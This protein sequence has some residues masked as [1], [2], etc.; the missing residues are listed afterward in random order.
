MICE[1]LMTARRWCQAPAL[2]PAAA[3][4]VLCCLSWVAAASDG[5]PVSP[6]TA[7]ELSAGDESADSSDQSAAEDAKIVLATQNCVRRS[8]IDT[9]RI[10]DD[11]TI[12]FY[13]RGPNIFLN[14]LPRRCSGLKISGTFGYDTRTNEL[15]NVDIIAVMQDFGGQIRPGVRCGLGKFQPVTEEQ[16]ALIKEV[17]AGDF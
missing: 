5:V 14:K 11:R 16:V 13:M 15:C 12:L 7:G 8:M 4:T 2:F 17:G 1:A 10:I 9:T 6:E 3:V